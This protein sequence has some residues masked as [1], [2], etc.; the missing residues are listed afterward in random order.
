[1]YNNLYFYFYSVE[2]QAFK[3][4]ELLQHPILDQGTRTHS[5]GRFLF[6]AFIFMQCA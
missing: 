6:L 2:N 3:E 5:S 1:M 4:M